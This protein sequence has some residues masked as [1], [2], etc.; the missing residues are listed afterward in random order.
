MPKQSLGRIDLENYRTGAVKVFR[1]LFKILQASGSRLV[2]SKFKILFYDGMLGIVIA[3]TGTNLLKGSLYDFDCV[4]QD[5]LWQH[6][7]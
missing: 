3:T 2:T 1:S 7:F 5:F 6:V 4:T